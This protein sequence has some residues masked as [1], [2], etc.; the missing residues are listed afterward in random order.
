MQRAIATTAS[1][2]H[3]SQETVGAIASER[4]VHINAGTKPICDNT[5]SPAPGESSCHTAVATTP[6][7]P[8]ASA[9]SAF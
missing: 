8:I 6:P 4:F 3:R 2:I 9:I 1:T 7:A 5:D